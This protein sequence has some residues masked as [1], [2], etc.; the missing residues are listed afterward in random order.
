MNPALKGIWE[1]MRNLGLGALAHANRHAAYDS[2]ENDR[3]PYLAV[4]QAAHAAELLLEARIAQEHPLLIFDQLPKAS[5]AAGEMLDLDDLLKQGRTVQ[6][7]D[8]PTASGQ[9][10]E[11]RWTVPNHVRTAPKCD[12]TLRATADG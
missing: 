12:S 1:N 8:L 9:R 10:L 11:S 6:W 4:L 2:W 7:T 3:W 5:G